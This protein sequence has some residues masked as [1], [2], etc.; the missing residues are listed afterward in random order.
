[1]FIFRKEGI[2]MLPRIEK[3]D[4]RSS[5]VKNYGQGLTGNAYSFAGK[6]EKCFSQI[7]TKKMKPSKPA[8]AL[9]AYRLDIHEL[10][11]L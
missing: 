4:P 11:R 9:A 7:L 1:M 10:P 3:I 8:Q 2:V 6:R 5:L